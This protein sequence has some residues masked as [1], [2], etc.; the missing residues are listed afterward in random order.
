MKALPEK[1]VVLGTGGG[2]LTIAAELETLGT[3][4]T[5]SDIKAFED[6]LKAV[7]RLG[8]IEITLNDASPKLVPVH[9]VSY[10]P[11]N[12]A[13][14]ADLIIIS[15]PCFGHQPFASLLAPILQDG[16]TVI[17]TGEGG[18][19][20]TTI[21]E[22]RKVGRSPKVTVAD[23]NSLPYGPA[24]VQSPGVV[25]SVQKKGG[26]YIAAIPT[27]ATNQ[28]HELALQI[29]PIIKPSANVWETL[30]VNF[31]AI[32]HV[33]TFMTNL[34][35]VENRR[36]VMKFW[37]EGL[38]PGVGRIIEG[39]DNELAAIR[40]GLGLL[41]PKQY[42]D[43]S[44]EQGIAPKTYPTIYETLRNSSIIYADFQCGPDV[45]KHRYIT[46][47]VPFAL[48]L[49]SSIGDELG[50]GTPVID[51]LVSLA[52]AASETDFWKE[53]RT[54]KTWGLDGKGREGLNNAVD[55]GWW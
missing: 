3:K 1:A 4:V 29:W 25:K 51:S 37:G 54:L 24:R 19:A 17:W 28:V 31:N 52:S 14:N 21:A 45:L 44:V 41:V 35:Q 49:A 30:L 27:N 33:A 40:R 9:E 43:Y 50:V 16:Q 32:D 15:V 47:D 23:T 39:V 2:S 55:Q 7:E 34:G 38:S 6:N 11:Q 26:T 5:L 42:K 20:F 22:L 10:N 36:D 18:G 12:A 48:V 13:K 53:G 46:E 8:G